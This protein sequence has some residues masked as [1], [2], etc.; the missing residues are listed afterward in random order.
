MDFDL[1]V[2]LQVRKLEVGSWKQDCRYGVAAGILL[3]IFWNI[4]DCIVF[5]PVIGLP[6]RFTLGLVTLLVGPRAGDDELGCM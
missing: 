2:G 6:T 4:L 5:T 1:E 3:E